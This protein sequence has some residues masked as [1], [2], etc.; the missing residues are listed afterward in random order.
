MLRTTGETQILP[1]SRHPRFPACALY[2]GAL[3]EAER[4]LELSVLER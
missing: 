4:D 3:Q 2:R 1:I